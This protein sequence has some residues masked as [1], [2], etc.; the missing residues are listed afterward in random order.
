MLDASA[1]WCRQGGDGSDIFGSLVGNRAG[2]DASQT[3]A[4]DVYLPARFVQGAL[5]NLVEAI[6]DQQVRTL[7]IERNTGGVGF[8]SEVFEPGIELCQ[9]AI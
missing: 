4:D 3:M 8:V 5:D 6:P 1:E 9:V 7:R 2:Y